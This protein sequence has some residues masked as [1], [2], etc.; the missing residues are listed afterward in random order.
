[1]RALA[2]CLAL[3]LVGAL[4]WAP[5]G[6]AQEADHFLMVNPGEEAATPERAGDFL[7]RM[8]RYLHKTVPALQDRP[9]RGWI[10]N[11]RDSVR[12]YLERDP[13]LAFVPPG[14]YLEH[15]RGDEHAT[16]VAELPRFGASAQ[17][18]HLVVPA[19]GP[20]TLDALRG[21]VVRLPEGTDRRYL[22]RVAAP[23]SLDLTADVQLEESANMDDEVF[24]LTEGPMGDDRPAD[25]LLFDED[26]KRFY[27]D[28]DFVWPELKVIWSSAPL[29]RDL[30]VALGPSWDADARQA[31]QE[32]LLTMSEHEEGEELLE[33]M[34]S[35]GFAS[36]NEERLS[37]I[38]RQYDAQ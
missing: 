24:L 33:L 7:D 34:N 1:M 32:A 38:A 28:D 30:V 8:G 12:A 3:L 25:A 4:L 18:Y 26:L 6:F 23:P 14:V 16:P 22:S 36:V 13:V 17:R 29:P 21:G 5:S 31:L 20:D 2:H 27:E 19:D 15:L 11:E 10:T 37:D 35:S 9:V